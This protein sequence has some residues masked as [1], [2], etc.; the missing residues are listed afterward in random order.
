MSPLL[1]QCLCIYAVSFSLIQKSKSS[2]P[3]CPFITA[4]EQA[5]IRDLQTKPSTACGRSDEHLAK[6]IKPAVAQQVQTPVH[7]HK[8]VQGKLAARLLLPPGG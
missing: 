8:P 3:N 7:D 6:V 2:F 1:S 4:E 5:H